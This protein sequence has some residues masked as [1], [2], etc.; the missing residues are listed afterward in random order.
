MVDTTS[1]LLSSLEGPSKLRTQAYNC[2]KKLIENYFSCYDLH[3]YSNI[4]DSLLKIIRKKTLNSGKVEIFTLLCISIDKLPNNYLSLI[5]KNF[6]EILSIFS[7]S[8][9]SDE[10]VHSCSSNILQFCCARL[11]SGKIT[12]VDSEFIVT[13][14]ENFFNTK[15]KVY[16]ETL[17]VLGALSM[18]LGMNFYKYLHRISSFVFFSIN[19][20]NSSEVL[21][22]G[23]LVLSDLALSL[24]NKISDYLNEI[25]PPLIKI[26]ESTEVTILCKILCINCL[27]DIAGASQDK[28]LAYLPVVLSFLDTA[29]GI[30]LQISGDIDLNLSLGE[31]RECIIQF[32]VGL[33]QG[34]AEC[35]SHNMIADRI[36][37]LITFISMVVKKEYS[38][39]QS[40][41]YATLGLLGDILEN[42]K[43]SGLVTPLKEYIKGFLGENSEL[44][45]TS[46][47]IMSMVTLVN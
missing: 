44:G 24:G 27:G 32:Y 29:A 7:D 34:L 8:L 9:K 40:L 2:L 19:Q 1:V 17:Q 42:Y 10:S 46:K 39:V 43:D 41:H 15:K 38:P 37:K 45:K 5:E 18:N 16:E 12:Q 22:S 21:K 36:P 20:L 28:F 33:V 26:L 13:T 35:N 14:I 30:S 3:Q 11:P 25:I 23:I 47:W 4:I 6:Q 31:L